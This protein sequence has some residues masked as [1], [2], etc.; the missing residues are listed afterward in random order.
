MEFWS[1]TTLIV[2]I[3]AL[4][5]AWRGRQVFVAGSTGFAAWPGWLPS[6]L[7]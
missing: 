2:M 6:C 7:F 5:I 3:S 4:Y 1:K